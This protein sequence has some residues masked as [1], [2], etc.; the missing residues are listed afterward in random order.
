MTDFLALS[1]ISQNVN[2]L[3]TIKAA[4]FGT[5]SEPEY[6]RIWSQPIPPKS[7]MK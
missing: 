6:G 1:Q 4:I 3:Y 7:F 2:I 5:T